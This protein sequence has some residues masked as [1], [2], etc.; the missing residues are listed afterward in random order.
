MCDQSVRR[1]SGHLYRCT[2]CLRAFLCL[3]FASLPAD[4][5]RL[6]RAVQ[7]F[8]TRIVNLADALR[9]LRIPRHHG[10]GLR[11]SAFSPA[12]QRYR[13][14]IS[15][16]A[17]QMK[18]SDTFNSSNSACTNHISCSPDCLCT[19]HR[20]LVQ[21]IHLRTTVRTAHRLRIITSVT[22]RLIFR[23]TLRTHGKL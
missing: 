9:H 16:I 10:K 5:N 4:H 6:L 11:R 12:K 18:A 21:K 13:R 20:R 7:Q 19:P 17:A 23:R 22:H 1:H 15:G 2:L 14:L 8:C 3:V